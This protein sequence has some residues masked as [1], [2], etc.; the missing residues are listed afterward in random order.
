MFHCQI[1]KCCRRVLLLLQCT[2]KM[3]YDMTYAKQTCK[4]NVFGPMGGLFFHTFTFQ[5]RD[6]PWSQVL[7]LLPPRFLPSIFI[8]HRVQ[9]SHC[10]SILNRVLLTDA[11]ALSASQFEKSPRSYTSM[12]SGGLEF[13]KLTCTRLQDN[14]IRHRGDRYSSIMYK[15]C[16]LPSI[17]RNVWYFSFCLSALFMLNLVRERLCCSSR[18]LFFC[19]ESSFEHQLFYFFSTF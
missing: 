2:N 6:K 17:Q 13:A 18:L 8:A 1:R 9:Q 15:V 19:F 10:S 3:S 11:L 14:L 12:H 16:H 7:S 4:T 5:L